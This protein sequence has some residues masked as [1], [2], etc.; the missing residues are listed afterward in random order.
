MYLEEARTGAFKDDR[1]PAFKEDR[2]PFE[3]D[4]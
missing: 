3:I 2:A 4:L 1:A